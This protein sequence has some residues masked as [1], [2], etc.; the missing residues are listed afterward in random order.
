MGSPELP[1]EFGGW[2]GFGERLN[3]RSRMRKLLDLF[4]VCSKPLIF[5]YPC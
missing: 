3:L 4:C 2:K 1:A 5:F